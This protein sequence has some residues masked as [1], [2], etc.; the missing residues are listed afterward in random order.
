MLHYW[1]LAESLLNVLT[2][3]IIHI[4]WVKGTGLVYSKIF[5]EARNVG[6]KYNPLTHWVSPVLSFNSLRVNAH[7]CNYRFRVVFSSSRVPFCLRWCRP[8]DEAQI[9]S[10]SVRK[11][12]VILEPQG[13][14]VSMA[15]LHS[16]LLDAYYTRGRCG[17]C[18]AHQPRLLFCTC[19]NCAPTQRSKV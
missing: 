8:A 10:S 7:A 3:F 15:D 19:A 17:S 4:L 9:R 1:S 11:P 13:G 2:L 18:C 14:H 16:S 5:I 12:S 6:L